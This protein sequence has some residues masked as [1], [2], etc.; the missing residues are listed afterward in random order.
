MRYRLPQDKIGKMDSISVQGV[1]YD[2]DAQGN[3]EAPELVAP[4]LAHLRIKGAVNVD[5]PTPAPVAAPTPNVTKS[6]EPANTP[7]LS[8]DPPPEFDVEAATFDQLGE[9]LKNHDL[10]VPASKALRKEAVKGALVILKAAE[11]DA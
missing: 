1:Q 9:W 6:E 7:V 11:E 5:P 8:N 3:F 10:E 4:H 2:I